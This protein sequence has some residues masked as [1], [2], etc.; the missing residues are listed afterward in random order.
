MFWSAEKKLNLINKCFIVISVNHY[1][2]KGLSDE[3]RQNFSVMKDLAQHTRIS[4]ATRA[5][6]L[7]QFMTDLHSNP[8]ASKE[9]AQWDMEFDRNLL[10]MTGRCL[11]AESKLI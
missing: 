1:Y 10:K 2:I 11:G 4:P 9:L 5:Q 8:E 7:E 6:N 3:I